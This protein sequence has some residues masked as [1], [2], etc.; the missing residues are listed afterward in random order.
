MNGSI[1]FQ[2]VIALL[3]SLGALVSIYINLNEKIARYEE[4]YTTLNA[5]HEELKA[6][7][8]QLDTKMDHYQREVTQALLTNSN[9]IDNLTKAISKLEKKLDM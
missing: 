1:T 5:K 6:W 2:A 8:E 7:V 9:S 3:T 4:R